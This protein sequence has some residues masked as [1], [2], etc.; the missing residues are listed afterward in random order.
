MNKTLIYIVV[1]VGGTLLALFS[2][3][4][5]TAMRTPLGGGVGNFIPRINSFA[6][7][8]VFLLPPKDSIVPGNRTD[9]IFGTTST[10]SYARIT[11]T[12]S[13]PVF[14]SFDDLPCSIDNARMVFPVNA[15][16]VANG[17]TNTPALIINENFPYT[18]T[19]RACSNSATS[20]LYVVQSIY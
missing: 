14:V 6:S 2:Y 9:V 18:G 17:S 8:V 1:T 4:S 12:G 3:Q 16:L 20:S 7:S 19:I 10:R 5:F 13:V 11:A 15:F